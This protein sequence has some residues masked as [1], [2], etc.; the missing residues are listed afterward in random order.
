MARR[1]ADVRTA[2]KVVAGAHPRDPFCVPAPFDGPALDRPVRV[3]LVP[4]PPGGSTTAAVTASVRSAGDAL[5]DAGYDV[6]EAE[7]PMIE[8]AIS[9]WARWLISEI[10]QLKPQLRLVMS[11][12]A[13]RFLDHAEASIGT[14]AYDE[15]VQLMMKR[16]EIA[17]AWSTF[18]LEHPVIVGPVWTGP[19]F[20]ADWDVESA[21]T[22]VATLELIR[23]VTPMNL[24][25]LPAAC[26]PT[27]IADGL[28]TG[29]QVIGRWFREDTC[30]E[31]AEAIE[32][33]LGSITPID[34]R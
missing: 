31:A 23:F 22:A 13:I 33:R 2:F 18:F 17:V 26:V 25:G 16:H 32:A 19:Q 10:A 30:F 4:E 14:V 5:A 34:P 28:P 11:E 21:E 29:V 1:V 24:L 20:A 7:P 27:G 8:E 6:V 12:D 9:T 3:A 15:S